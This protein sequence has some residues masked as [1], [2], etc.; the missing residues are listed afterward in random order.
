LHDAV[1]GK[2]TTGDVAVSRQDCLWHR[3]V[4][5]KADEI[6]DIL[7]G[8]LGEVCFLCSR[9]VRW[10][11]KYPSRINF[12][13]QGA[14]QRRQISRKGDFLD[15]VAFHGRLP[16]KYLVMIVAP[17]SSSQAYLLQVVHAL[18]ATATQGWSRKHG[19][20]NHD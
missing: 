12:V 19:H 4:S 3:F 9:A 16:R 2:N 17:Q 18:D 7:V 10:T 5:V 13:G 1:A 8:Q 14:K 6:A 11:E 20:R 15:A